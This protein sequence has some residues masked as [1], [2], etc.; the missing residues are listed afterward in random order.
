MYKIKAIIV[1]FVI[2]AFIAGLALVGIELR[3]FF[4][5][6]FAQMGRQSINFKV[7]KR[8]TG[9]VAQ[10]D[11]NSMTV[12]VMKKVKDKEAYMTFAVNYNTSFVLGTEKKT[13]ADLKV[14]DKVTVVY[15]R[16][17][18]RFIAQSISIER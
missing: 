17:N 11:T 18:D 10:I 6:S 4:D 2:F 9:N 8:F 14:G 3:G 16:E 7:K 15:F 12:K 1:S 13:I 5:K